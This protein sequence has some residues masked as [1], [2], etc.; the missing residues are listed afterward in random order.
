MLVTGVNGFVGRALG[1]YLIGKGFKVRAAVRSHSATTDQS[2]VVGDINGKTS[3]SKALVDCDYVVHLAARVHIMSD[4]AENPR[5][6]YLNTNTE[7]TR[8]LARQAS[9]A[10]V[11]RFIY[12]SSIK[13]NGEC[14]TDMPFTEDDVPHPQDDYAVSKLEA[15]QALVSECKQSD[16]EYVIIRPPLVYGPG[17]RANFL[18]LLK[19]V[20]SHIPLPLASLHNKRSLVALD[21]L[22]DFIGHAL[23]H[24]KAANEIFLISDGE[25][26]ST[27][28]LI[29][30]IAVAFNQSPRLF[31]F[32][33]SI[34]K[35]FQRLQNSLQLDISKAVELLDWQPVVSQDDAI[36]Q[37]ADWFTG[38]A[39]H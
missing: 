21:N 37:T 11:K 34:L 22:V 23:T 9:A 2:L 27:P 4:Q 17:V 24:E 10:G 35:A 6:L 33:V 12:I 14:T 1:E 20:H 32:P 25:N 19:L 7:G 13:V 30:K 5:D 31:S 36:R 3:W 18:S 16:M 28:Q 29:N 39:L 38:E 15:E 8:N 26:I